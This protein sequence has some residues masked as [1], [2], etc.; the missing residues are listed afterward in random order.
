MFKDLKIDK[1]SHTYTLN[2]K[3][4]PSVSS[5]LG[6]FY[7]PFNPVV[8]KYVARR[9]GKTEAQV[10]KEW[11]TG[12]TIAINKGHRVHDFAENWANGKLDYPRDDQ[13]MGVIQ[14]WLDKPDSWD[15][16][17]AELMAYSKTY[18]YAGTMDLLFLNRET[19][20]YVIADWKTNKDL[21]KNYKK[22]KLLPPFQTWL[23]NPLNKYKIQLNYYQLCLEELGFEIERRVVVWLHPKK[24]KLYQEFEVTDLTKRLKRY[25][26]TRRLSKPTSSKYKSYIG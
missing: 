16:V 23:D 4:L 13:E 10:L 12:N 9:D 25:E 17:Q 2:G 15:L 14:W 1:A 21:F 11:K 6:D 26:Q 20:K 3:V 5:K 8:A 18:S 22:Q 7:K 19:G 24:G